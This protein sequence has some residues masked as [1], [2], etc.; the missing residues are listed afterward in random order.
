VFLKYPM[1]VYTPP[2]KRFPTQ[3]ALSRP[4][5]VVTYTDAAGQQHEYPVDVL[6]VVKLARP[7]KEDGTA[8]ESDSDDNGSMDAAD[9]LDQSDDDTLHAFVQ[10][11]R[12]VFSKDDASGPRHH[13]YVPANSYVCL[14]DVFDL[15]PVRELLRPAVLVPVPSQQSPRDSRQ[16][17]GKSSVVKSGIKEDKNAERAHFNW[18]AKWT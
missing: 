4:A 1:S 16:H 13:E 12:Y 9:L 3:A 6:C 2:V 14:S 15:L 17:G 10:A 5:A 18:I 11:Y 8:A 7:D